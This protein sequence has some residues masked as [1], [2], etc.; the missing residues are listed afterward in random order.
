M[1][2]K[3]GF[4]KIIKSTAFIYLHEETKYIVKENN[5]ETKFLRINLRYMW[6]TRKFKN[7]HKTETCKDITNGNA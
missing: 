2:N 6:P 3:R 5:S 7:I 1:Y 4:I